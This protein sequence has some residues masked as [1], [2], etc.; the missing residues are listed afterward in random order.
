MLRVVPR[1]LQLAEEEIRVVR[2]ILDQQNTKLLA[3]T[4]STNL[5]PH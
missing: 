5:G 1:A 4:P 2:G 3:H